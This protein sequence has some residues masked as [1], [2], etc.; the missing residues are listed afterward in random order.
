MRSRATEAP[1]QGPGAPRSP[2]HGKG[3]VPSLQPS[4]AESC[5]RFSEARPPAFGSPSG[6]G[7]ATF[8]SPS[9]Q[10]C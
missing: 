2:K 4:W 7:Q 9:F 6:C 8:L 5:C 3:S 1:A 10:L